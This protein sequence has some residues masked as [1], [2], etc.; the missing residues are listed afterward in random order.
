MVAVTDWF[1]VKLAKSRRSAHFSARPPLRLDGSA[2]A[3]CF[4]AAHAK[5]SEGK[6]QKLKPPN[7]PKANGDDGIARADVA[8]KGAPRPEGAEFPIAAAQHTDADT[9]RSTRVTL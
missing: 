5:D 2:P 6:A 4:I 1:G 9:S 7:T 3:V 8:A